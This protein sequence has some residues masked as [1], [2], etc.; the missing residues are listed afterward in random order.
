MKRCLRRATPTRKAT[1]CPSSPRNIANH[2]PKTVR[3]NTWLGCNCSLSATM[4]Q[5]S[6][7]CMVGG[8]DRI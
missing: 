3:D 5:K 2:S 6:A 1:G 8:S 7:N 4:Y